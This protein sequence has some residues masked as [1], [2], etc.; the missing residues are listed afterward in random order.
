MLQLYFI[1][2]GQSTNNVVMDEGK[3]EDYLFNRVTDPVLTEKGRRQADLVAD[4]LAREV[5]GGHFDPQNRAGFGLTHLYCSLMTRSIETGLPIARK[6]G[7]PLVALTDGH[8]TGGM[9]RA[10]KQDGETVLIGLPGRG[11]S[12]LEANYPELVL[13]EDLTDAGWWNREKEPREAYLP[14]AR[15]LIDFFV[16]THGG[17]HHRVG[18][19]THGAI[20]ARIL[21]VLFDIQ[22]E[23]YW[24]LMNNCGISRI[25]ISDEGEVLLAYMN[26]VDCLPR[27]LLT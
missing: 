16:Q 9:F 2:H 13:P 27:D 4:Y 11:R 3:R 15:R 23:H 8:E 1:R 22:A 7:L 17:Q 6:T 14:R 20:F 18:V 5:D 25:E 10:E 21:T 12:D 19:V 26:K 24:F